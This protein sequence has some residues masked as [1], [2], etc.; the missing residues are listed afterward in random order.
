MGAPKLRFK[1]FNNSWGHAE[2]GRFA[3]INPNTGSLP[4]S[5]YYIDLESVV[6]GQFTFRNKIFK[7]NAPSRAQRNLATGDVL[8]QTVRP[9]QQNNLFFNYTDEKFVASTGYAHI[10]TKYDSKFLYFLLHT[11]KFLARV[12]NKCE[13]GNYPAINTTN[14]KKI[15]VEFPAIEEQQKIADFLTSVDDKINLLK[16]KKELLEQYKKGVMQK[17]FSQEL[18]FKDEEGNDFPEWEEYKLKDILNEH[19]CKNVGSQV[20]EVFSV[21]K[22]KGVINQI[23]HLGRSFAA[24]T[25]SHYKVLKPHDVVYTKSPTSNFPF[26]IIKQNK[27]GRTGIVSPL[28]G[29]FTPQTPQLGFILDYY[30]SVWQNTFNY[31]NPLVQKGAKNT[32][33]IHND[34]FLNGSELSLPTSPHEQQKIAD[35]LTALDDKIALVERQINKTELWK[36]GLLQQMFV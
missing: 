15:I 8:F 26:G 36:K 12:L 24:T 20:K 14:L 18:R 11:K 3:E 5:F 21:A 7:V 22:S 4:D 6:K 32:M 10:R 35:F 1:G 17:I 34:T 19:G 33:N 9:Y 16:K 29:V 31:L 28:Y 30:F 27:T 13:G 23:E 2:L 25:V